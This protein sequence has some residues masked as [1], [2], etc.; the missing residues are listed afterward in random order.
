MRRQSVIGARVWIA[1]T[2]I[3]WGIVVILIGFVHTSTGKQLPY[4]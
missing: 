4:Y 3:S 2:L 1:R